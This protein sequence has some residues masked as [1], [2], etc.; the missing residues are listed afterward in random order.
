MIDWGHILPYE[1]N[2]DAGGFIFAGT[3]AAASNHL[4]VP[5]SDNTTNEEERMKR[6]RLTI[7]YSMI[8]LCISIL[9]VVA[10][11]QPPPVGGVLPEIVLPA[12]EQPEHAAYLGIKGK[13]KFAI[14]DIDA[15]IV[16]VEIFSMY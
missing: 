9:T 5:P 7:G 6:F 15:T 14:P 16:I 8:F 13:Q 4:P 10:A 2:K 3:R 12:P 11:T 1:N